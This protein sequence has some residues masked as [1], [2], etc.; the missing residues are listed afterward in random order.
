MLPLSLTKLFGL[1]SLILCAGNPEPCM[2][3]MWSIINLNGVLFWI[4]DIEDFADFD[5][6]K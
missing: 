3:R 2:Y 5:D 4:S 1:Y 6:L